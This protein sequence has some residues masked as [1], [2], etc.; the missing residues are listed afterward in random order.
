MGAKGSGRLNSGQFHDSSVFNPY[1]TSESLLFYTFD[2]S[3]GFWMT[4]IRHSPMKLSYFSC[5][6]LVLMY[7]MTLITLCM[8]SN[9]VSSS[10]TIKSFNPNFLSVT[11]FNQKLSLMCVTH[12]K[13]GYFCLLSSMILK[14]ISLGHATR[15]FH[16][17]KLARILSQLI[18]F[19]LIINF[20]FIGIVNPGML[21]PGPGSLKIC[22]HNVQGLIPIKDLT[23]KQ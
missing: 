18:L 20:L 15:K 3:S 4:N 2:T 1:N 11:Y 14:N 9:L 6:V 5:Y 19:L 7:V 16:I 22:Y 10:F 8:F 21:N 12:I 17:L 23:L 13:I